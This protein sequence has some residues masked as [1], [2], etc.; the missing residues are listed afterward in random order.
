MVARELNGKQGAAA[1]RVGGDATSGVVCQ[2]GGFRT[3]R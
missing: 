2:L 3:E 1:L